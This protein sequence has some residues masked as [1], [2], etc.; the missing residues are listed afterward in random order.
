MALKN[1][2]PVAVCPILSQLSVMS[3]DLDGTGCDAVAAVI[4]LAPGEQIDEIGIHVGRGYGSS[5]FV[6][7]VEE[8]DG[9]DQGKPIGYLPG[10][11]SADA[12]SASVSATGMLNDFVWTPLLDP[13]RNTSGQPQIVAL[14]IREGSTS[15]SLSNHITMN[16]GIANRPGE[17]FPYISTEASGSWSQA[18]AMPILVAKGAGKLLASSLWVDEIGTAGWNTASTAD[19]YQ[20]N[21]WHVDA[22]CR[23][24]AVS[25]SVQFAEGGNIGVRVYVNDVLTTNAT[26]TEASASAMSGDI[27]ENPGTI[28]L[29]IAPVVL[30]PGDV[31][32]MVLEPLTMD[33][34]ASLPFLVFAN[35][36][37]RLQFTHGLD[38]RYTAGSS[39]PVWVDAD[40]KLAGIT[41]VIDQTGGGSS[42]GS[43]GSVSTKLSVRSGKQ[44][45]LA[46]VF[47][48]DVTSSNG[49]GLTGLTFDA[50]GL[51]AY[52][53]RSDLEE[54]VGFNS[55]GTPGT[56]AEMT[57]GEW[58][59]S[60][61]VEI[62]DETL[63]GWYQLGIPDDAFAPGAE[64]VCI[65]LRGATGMP[66]VNIEI[67]IDQEVTLAPR[68]FDN[69]GAP[70]FINSL[71][72]VVHE[73]VSTDLESLT[74]P[75]RLWFA[76][77]WVVGGRVDNRDLKQLSILGND[78]STPKGVAEYT[79][80]GGIVT[81]NNMDLT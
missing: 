12:K 49:E 31:V 35:S 6:V 11:G 65:V 26:L 32:R 56:L 10:I 64:S 42:S 79:D 21:I 5:T 39:T 47:I 38:I 36:G 16:V 71:E 34:I 1:I 45:F 37:N 27:Q 59:D 13:Y 29:P 15:F 77:Q 41:P 66:Q 73:P 9:S 2:F 81:V 74:W 25:F 48:P 62:D 4:A 17:Y 33:G 54:P 75:E 70:T 28:T 18:G 43:N 30:Q 52:Y 20:G 14:T 57:L 60:G 61:F 22:V 58:E 46:Q 72:A 3:V 69:L 19:L 68:G 40:T 63:P 53:M 55:G 50:V 44:S 8:L 7:G 24:S 23:M 67:A 51:S 76:S 78:N 80:V